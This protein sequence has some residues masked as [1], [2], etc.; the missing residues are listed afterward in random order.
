VQ[1]PGSRATP[2]QWGRAQASG[3][4]EPGTL[5][6]PPRAVSGSE[7]EVALPPP[8]GPPLFLQ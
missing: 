4:D 2:A 3:R 1:E 7:A 6:R 8:R 5:E